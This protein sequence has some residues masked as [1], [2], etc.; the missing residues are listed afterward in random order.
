MMTEAEEN[1]WTMSSSTGDGD[2]DEDGDE[3]EPAAFVAAED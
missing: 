3:A 1:R 2:G